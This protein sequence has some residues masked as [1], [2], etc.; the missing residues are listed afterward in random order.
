[1]K[2]A[3]ASE[4]LALSLSLT[5][6]CSNQIHVSSHPKFQTDIVE[7]TKCLEQQL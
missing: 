2:P 1:M 7:Q 5:I 6:S 3:Q 4:N